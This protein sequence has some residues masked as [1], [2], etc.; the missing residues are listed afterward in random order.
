MERT[1]KRGGDIDLKRSG[2]WLPAHLIH[3]LTRTKALARWVGTSFSLCLPRCSHRERIYITYKRI[4]LAIFISYLGLQCND[5]RGMTLVLPI[6]AY[7][8]SIP[9]ARIGE[10][11]TVFSTWNTRNL[12][13]K[14]TTQISGKHNC[15]LPLTLFTFRVP[16]S[17]STMFSTPNG[18]LVSDLIY[19]LPEVICWNTP[20]HLLARYV[21]VC[22]LQ[23]LFVH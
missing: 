23:V 10:D 9:S 21:T 13:N 16:K 6:A 14:E 5:I 1:W 19:F 15:Q 7:S 12:D 18:F 4:Q 20:Y 11:P 17:T 22:T 3:S 2:C 8:P